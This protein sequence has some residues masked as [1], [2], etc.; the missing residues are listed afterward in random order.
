MF[1][2]AQPADA[3]TDLEEILSRETFRAGQIMKHHRPHKQADR[4]SACCFIDALA[5]PLDPQQGSV[6]YPGCPS[7]PN[8]FLGSFYF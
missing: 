3:S 6:A 8:E 1:R 2:I 7:G 4:A 5:S